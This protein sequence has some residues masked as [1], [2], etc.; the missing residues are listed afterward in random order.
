MITSSS[1]S[2]STFPSAWLQKCFFFTICWP[3]RECPLPVT[4]RVMEMHPHLS[5]GFTAM[6]KAAKAVQ[7]LH[8]KSW[9]TT[10]LLWSWTW[11]QRDGLQTH[12]IHL[13]HACTFI[14]RW[15]ITS[16][17]PSE[18][19]DRDSCSEVRLI[20]VIWSKTFLSSVLL[21]LRLPGHSNWRSQ[22][23][24]CATILKYRMTQRSWVQF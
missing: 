13:E 1:S 6:V 15:S 14:H 17:V 22:L 21:P 7:I 23:K 9:K 12:Y 5:N 19:W 18:R 8:V 16:P 20:W 2:S 24:D 4:E 3:G 10:A 11:I